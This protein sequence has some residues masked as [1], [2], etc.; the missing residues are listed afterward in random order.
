MLGTIYSDCR[1]FVRE[2][3]MRV[4]DLDLGMANSPVWSG[5]THD[6]H[7]AK[8]LLVELDRV[9]SAV[10]DHI[11]CGGVISL[12][13]CFY[14]ACHNIPPHAIVPKSGKLPISRQGWFGVA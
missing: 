14:G 9:R 13:N 2:H 6:L 8:R 4:A 1:M 5:H 7:C 12:W 11:R 3:D 10:A